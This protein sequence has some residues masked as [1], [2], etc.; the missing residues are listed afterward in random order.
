M[1]PLSQAM[2]SSPDPDDLGRYLSLM[3]TYGASDL[4]LSSDVAASLNLKGVVG[5]RR[6][7]GAGGKRVP[8]VEVML[9][10]PYIADLIQMG[11][12][13]EIKA[14]IAKSTEMGMM[15]FDQSLYE[16]YARGDITQEQAI[17]HADSKTDLSLRIRLASGRR[18]ET[19][20]LQVLRD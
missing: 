8:A 13:D 19:E 1:P 7:L 16:L 11:Q 15:T 20:A 6:R 18:P 17:E 14:A 4:F 10:S 3:V 5:Q 9:L 2:P 12:T